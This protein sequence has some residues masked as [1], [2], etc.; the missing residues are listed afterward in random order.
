MVSPSRSS[1]Q[2]LPAKKIS[3]QLATCTFFVISFFVF[4]MTIYT[5]TQHNDVTLIMKRF[6]VCKILFA[7]KPCG[8]GQG[9]QSGCVPPRQRWPRM[10]SCPRVRQG[11]VNRWSSVLDTDRTSCCQD[12]RFAKIKTKHIMYKLAGVPLV[13]MFYRGHAQE[14]ARYVYNVMVVYKI[15]AWCR[16]LE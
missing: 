13:T 3:S 12:W 9:Q 4:F 5:N 7:N 11:S 16:W 14:W 1:N 15:N 10:T 6:V 2:L 8:N